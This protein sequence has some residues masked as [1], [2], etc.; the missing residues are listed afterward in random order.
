LNIVRKAF[1][2]WEALELGISFAEVSDPKDAMIRIGFDQEDGSWSLVGTEVRSE[3][4]PNLRTMNFGWPLD[5][6]DYGLTTALHEIGHSLGLEH[7]HQNPKSGIE[8]NVDAVKTYFEGPPNNWEPDVIQRNVLDKLT[9]SE[10]KGTKWDPDS[11]MEYQFEA[12]LIIK[13][14]DYRNG[15]TPK[16]DLSEEDITWVKQS[17]P[18]SSTG[19]NVPRLSVEVAK[20]LD[21]GIGETRTFIFEPTETRTYKIGTSGTADTT[22][23]VFQKTVSGNV[24]LAA[25]EDSGEDRNALV[26]LKLNSGN[27]YEIGVRLHFAPDVTKA[28]IKVW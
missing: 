2:G 23:V 3:G 6:N 22:V 19:I 26:E 8:W 16:G 12:G 24:Q 20:G 9:L 10:V 1:Q 21:L 25:D 11:I 27:T 18:D 15:L 14:A 4:D 7:E 5:E 13:P 28:S 17:Y